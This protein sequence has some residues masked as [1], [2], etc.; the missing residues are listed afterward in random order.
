MSL[1]IRK[2]KEQRLKTLYARVQGLESMPSVA[3]QGRSIN[4]D[5]TL[6]GIWAEIRELE[7]ELRAMMPFEHSTPLRNY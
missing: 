3:D 6:T 5:G 4:T 7:K 1:D 2:L